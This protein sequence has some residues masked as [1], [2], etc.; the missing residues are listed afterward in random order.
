MVKTADVDSTCR[1][2]VSMWSV[3]G[4]F[5]QKVERL[6]SIRDSGIDACVFK[7]AA[8]LLLLRNGNESNLEIPNWK[9]GS[10]H[11]EADLG[12]LDKGSPQW[13]TDLNR[14]VEVSLLVPGS[15]PENTAIEWQ[16]RPYYM[17]R[18]GHRWRGALP[19]HVVVF[20]CVGLLWG[21]EETRRFRDVGWLELKQASHLLGFQMIK[22]LSK[23]TG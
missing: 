22:Q 12:M 4:R 6:L 5:V 3:L 13:T 15:S 14:S 21:M 1:V 10:W 17:S 8:L 16:L 2:H 20:Y 18:R 9:Q 23:D 7:Y 19:R 11:M